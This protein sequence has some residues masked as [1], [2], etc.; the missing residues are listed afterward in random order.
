MVYTRFVEIGR[1]VLINAGPDANKLAVIVD[2]IDSNRA[3]ID[4]PSS[5]VSRQA[6]N[7]RNLSLTDFKIK[8][9]HSA[10]SKYVAK[11]YEAAEITKKWEATSWAKKLV[12]RAKRA[13]LTDFERFVVK[14]N[15]QARAKIINH[16]F[17][18]LKRAS[19]GAAAP[20]AKAPVAKA[21]AAKAPAAAKPK[22]AA[23]AK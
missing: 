13:S 14:A 23:K 5:G 6:I 2:V 17:N 4:G 20:A 18:K 10:A 3:L 9:G 15:K 22:A 8:I 19:K 7:F 1:V 21:P 12:A 16:A 11:A